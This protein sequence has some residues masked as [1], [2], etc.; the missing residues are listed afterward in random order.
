MFSGSEIIHQQAA[1]TLG[2]SSRLETVRLEKSSGT[3][4]LI[5]TGNQEIGGN[6]HFL[7]TA[8]TQFCKLGLC[9]TLNRGLNIRMRGSDYFCPIGSSSICW[10]MLKTAASHRC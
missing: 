7:R 10:W 2:Y 9:H 5:R 3:S 8:G 6:Y 4:R 1:T